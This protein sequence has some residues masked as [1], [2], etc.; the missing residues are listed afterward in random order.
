MTSSHPYDALT[1]D[2][3]LDAVESLGLITDACVLALN[4][5]ENR[6][7]QIGIDESL[8]VIAKFYRPNRWT[9]EQIIE[10]HQFS[11]E[12]AAQEIPV[13]APTVIDGESLFEFSGFYFCLFERRGGH[14][15]EIDNFEHLYRLGQIMGQIHQLGQAKSFIHRPVLSKQEFGIDA[16]E[17]VLASNLLPRTMHDAY[18]ST[19]EHL[20]PHCDINSNC[21][22][23]LH[24]DC[25]VGNILWRDDSFLF[26][27]FDD[28]RQGPA[29][30]D[31]FMFLNGDQ[32]FQQQQLLELLEGYEEFCEFDASELRLVHPLRSLRM[33]NYAGWLAKRWQDPAF[34]KAFTW[35]EGERFWGEHINGLREQLAT[36]GEPPLK[37]QM[38]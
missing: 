11:L 21:T 12:L 4:S 13:I 15:P 23:R 9:R 30:Q 22:T 33:I 8:P 10:E 14:A 27:D 32:H 34:K 1:P 35:F 3:V 29:I 24:G 16:V 36:V 17:H 38:F 2:T 37:R 7:Y 20:L 25:H 18:T 31:L 26:V 5:Y 19:I 28:C 6:V